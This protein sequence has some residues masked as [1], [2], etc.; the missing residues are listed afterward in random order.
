[1]SIFLL[2]GIYCTHL[3]QSYWIHELL[4]TIYW[5]YGITYHGVWQTLVLSL[6]VS[7]QLLYHYL[8]QLSCVTHSLVDL[9]L[10]VIKPSFPVGSCQL[11]KIKSSIHKKSVTG[12]KQTNLIIHFCWAFTGLHRSWSLLLNIIR[13]S[14]CKTRQVGH[15][16]DFATVHSL[17]KSYQLLWG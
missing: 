7:H 8:M 1:M 6:I 15:T 14:M 4:Q 3:L 2:L 9:H 10:I 5:Y 11:Y 13:Y 16:S 12:Y 17:F